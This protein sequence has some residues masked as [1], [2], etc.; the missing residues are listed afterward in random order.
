M[1]YRL[2]ISLPAPGVAQRPCGYAFAFKLTG[3]RI[4]AHPKAAFKQPDAP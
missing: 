2:A 3:F 1:K 4:C